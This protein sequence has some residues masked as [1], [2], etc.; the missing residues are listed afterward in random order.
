MRRQ[1]FWAIVL[2]VVGVVSAS[3]QTTGRVVGQAQDASGAAVPG[4]SVTAT[5]PQ[6]QGSLSTTTDAGGNFRFLSVPPG[7][8]KVRAELAGFKTVEQASVPVGLDRTAT[9]AFRMEVAPVA[10][11]VTVEGGAVIDVT[12][13]STG[14]NA[15][16]ELFNRIPVPRDIYGITRVAPGTQDDGVGPTFYGSSGAENQYIIE[17][18]NTTGIEVGTKGK[19]LN[20][21]FVQEV[22]IKTGG[23]PAEYGR[24]TGGVIN[25]LT[26]SGGNAFHGSAF[27]FFEGKGL[28]SNNSTAS[29]RP[30]T[31]T[32]VSDINQ[33]WDFGGELGGY[34]VKDKLWFFGAYN[35][36]GET[37]N[38][39]IIRDLSIP[40]APSL[41]AVIPADVTSNR[42]AGKLTWKLS[43][44]HTLTGSAFG[45][46]TTR[47]GNIFAIAGPEST[48]K[49][50]LDTGGTD[51]VGRYDG[52]ITSSFLIRAMAGR[53]KEKQ[54]YGGPGKTLNQLRD[55]TVNPNINSGGFAFFQDEKFSRDVYLLGLTKFAGSHELKLGG[56]LEDIKT[57]IDRAY[58]GG[59]LIYKL[60]T[61]GRTYYRH[62]YFVNDRAAGFDRN[63]PS[64]WQFAF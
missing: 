30:Q 49:G 36:T 61:G 11:T 53:H 60:V 34:L 52:V 50:T 55:Q 8:Y 51:F 41:G 40:G 33:K 21:D 56:D 10:E 24:M 23:L 58:G 46:P 14:I 16:P 31:T 15:T 6:L 62:R 43:E 9:L 59:S 32:T 2:L 28:Q 18:L 35:R 57:D 5:S 25:V 42:F 37:D 39:T 12:S 29:L 4:V 38:T 48:W 27:G 20:F 13:T 22:E 47:D 44:N 63:N 54:L 3:G 19:N 26:K 45:D 17:G 7:S 64:T 1:L